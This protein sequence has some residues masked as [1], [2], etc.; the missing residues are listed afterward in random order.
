MEESDSPTSK[1]K[2]HDSAGSINS[3]SGVNAQGDH[4]SSETDN[5]VAHDENKAK[6]L[7]GEVIRKW[8]STS[9]HGGN[10]KHDVE[11]R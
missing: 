7:G 11:S 8:K 10:G 6:V 1:I 9:R 5:D 4:A 3:K 2:R